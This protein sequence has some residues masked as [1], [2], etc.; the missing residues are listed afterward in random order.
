MR[1]PS[2]DWTPS[3]VVQARY[4]VMVKTTEF[5]ETRR[6]GHSENMQSIERFKTIVFEND[7]GRNTGKSVADEM[8]TKKIVGVVGERSKSALRGLSRQNVRATWSPSSSQA[9]K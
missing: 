5:G 3:S 4:L 7:Q 8:N 6:S 2:C 9:Q 1:L